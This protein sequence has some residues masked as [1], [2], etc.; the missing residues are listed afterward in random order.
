MYA[1]HP[2][3]ASA[4]GRPCSLSGGY[5]TEYLKAFINLKSLIYWLL[6][7]GQLITNFQKH[8]RPYLLTDSEEIVTACD[9]DYKTS[10]LL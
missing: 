6:N 10:D 8:L 3:A 5:N 7:S 9:S 2:R 1:R 4:F